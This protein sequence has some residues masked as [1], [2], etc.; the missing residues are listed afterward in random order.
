MQ[1]TKSKRFEHNVEK[2]LKLAGFHVKPEMILGHKKVDLYAEIFELGKRRRY[3]VECKN[4]ERAMTSKQVQA[5]AVDYGQLYEQN[6]IDMVLIVTK[7]GLAPSAQTYVNGARNLAH[8][9]L[10]D[11]QAWVMDFSVFLDSLISEYE[12]DGLH[13]YYVPAWVFE[14]EDGDH[15]DLY[16]LVDSWM[17]DD[18]LAPIALL[19][20]YGS[21]KTTFARHMAYRCAKHYKKYHMGRIPILIQLGELCTEQTI[22]GLLGRLFASRYTVRG[23]SFGLFQ[24][25]NRSGSFLVILDGFDEM[26]YSMTSEVFSFTFKELLKIV[27]PKSKVILSG[28]PSAFL[29]DAERLE[30]LHASVMRGG[31]NFVIKGRPQFQEIMLAPF[32]TEQIIT[33]IDKYRQYLLTE[34][35][36][37]NE[38]IPTRDDF[39]KSEV[40]V[41]LASRPVQLEMLFEVLPAYKGNISDLTVRELYFYFVE[42][43]VE[44]EAEKP[45]RKRF[46]AARRRDFLRALA[47]YMWLKSTPKLPMEE[48][49]VED[50][51]TTSEINELTNLDDVRRDLTT[52]AFLEVRYPEQVFFP[53]RSIQEYLLSEF[54]IGYLREEEAC[55]RFAQAIYGDITLPFID[56]RASPEV[57]DFMVASMGDND[58]INC[59][60]HLQ[61]IHQA[62]TLRVL[63]LWTS[64]PTIWSVLRDRAED[65]E[66]WPF[67]L[68][69]IGC[70]EASWLTRP[71][72][73][74]NLYRTAVDL[75]ASD[76]R[77]DR[78]F[79]Y[80]AFYLSWILL[81]SEK[82]QAIRDEWMSACLTSLL[83]FRHNVWSP[84]KKRSEPSRPS[85]VKELLNSLDF[86][87]RSDLLRFVGLDRHIVRSSRPIG[88]I[89]WYKER[90]TT[91]P[92]LVNEFAVSEKLAPLLIREK[93]KG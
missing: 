78:D 54:L 22:D 62:L 89:S 16:E 30:F 15:V 36:Y 24:E 33:F 46:S 65:G 92:Q 74:I 93:K 39:F 38:E 43:L 51:C 69:V 71:G 59:L 31:R 60:Y 70:V 29:N 68:L 25:L 66:M 1:E 47:F 61:D 83:R 8:M 87:P 35:G 48:I 19:G 3:A 86:D 42:L 27:T 45:A 37:V 57:I 85:F 6:L 28:R 49:P 12:E 55:R 17:Q 67:A 72:E 2:L 21:G 81:S 53:H 40:L 76:D 64:S 20:G 44:R 32:S 77:K 14:R 5:I 63:R 56:E 26:K 91:G 9:T 79:I 50:F 82:D 88:L 41:E 34:K 13:R 80:H 18:S 90:E 75:L 52:G 58:R 23:Y 10:N 73:R 84:I 11:L 7:S 4:W